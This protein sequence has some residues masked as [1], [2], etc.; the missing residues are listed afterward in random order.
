MLTNSLLAGALGAA[1]LTI[2]VLQ[3]NPQI[4]LVSGTTWRWFATLALLYGLHLAVTFYLLIVVREFFALRVLSP[5]WASVRD[6][7]LDGCRVGRGG[8]D[9][10]VAER[11]RVPYRPDRRCDEA[12]DR[13]R[14]RHDRVGGV[15]LAIAIAH[16]SF[17]R[18]GSRVGA[19]LFVLA[20]FASL[21]LPL[22]ARGDAVERPTGISKRLAVQVSGAASGG[23]AAGHDDPARR[24]LARLRAAAR[25][26]R[27]AA[28]IRASF[29]KRAR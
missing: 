20:A 26:R 11:P 27:T 22:A 12:N 24:R 17:G 10:D 4:P 5:G 29:L 7:G 14:A 16:Y 8:I 18:R 3:L 21:A 1:Y 28:R 2:L 13:R 25:R 19:S 6:A 9:L 23:G 15:L